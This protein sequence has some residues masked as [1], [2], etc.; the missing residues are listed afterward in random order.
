MAK[1]VL[2]VE[3]NDLNMKL[4]RD[5]VE[6]QGYEVVE[7]RTGADAYELARIFRPGLILMD[8]QLP[9]QSGLEIARALKADSELAKI[10]V[11]AVTA[12]AMRGDEQRIREAG[13]DAY[14]SK[15]V[16]VPNFI[17][18]VKAYLGDA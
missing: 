13:C 17:K 12:F 14:L 9:E 8:I 2:I 5:L 4:F 7:S 6:A 15:P 10:P 1:Q 16:S 18:T 3:D 11:I